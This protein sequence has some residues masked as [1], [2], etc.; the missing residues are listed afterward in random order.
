[1]TASENQPKELIEIVLDTETTGLS[2]KS[3]DRVIEIGCVKLI[4]R[5]KTNE[6]FHA[7]LNPMRD[8]P[9]EAFK[10]HGI[11]TEFLQDKPT[12]SKIANE[13]LDFIGTASTLIIHN[14]AFDIGF[15]NAEL[16]LCG[17]Q[18]IPLGRTIDTLTIARKKFP[19][20]PASLEA[21]CVRFNISLQSRSKH[22]ALIDADL[23]SAVYIEL[24]GGTQS[25]LSF[26]S[27]NAYANINLKTANNPVRKSRNF[28]PSQQE[29]EQH[30]AL[31]KLIKSPVWNEE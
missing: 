12:F 9:E 13:F 10:V 22:G 28:Q 3:G 18:N 30:S 15:L 11:S 20:A 27:H 21:L 19:G 23:L 6:V 2:P 1:M 8:V 29:L 5:I 26:D 14:A 16:A 7:Y 17:L 4:N 31:L 25:S 24:M